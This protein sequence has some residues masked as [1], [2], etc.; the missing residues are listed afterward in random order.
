V[1]DDAGCKVP[2]CCP[3][4]VAEPDGHDSSAASQ[5]RAGRVLHLIAAETVKPG[6]EVKLRLLDALDW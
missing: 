4:S 2:G 1:A 6:V 5:E 3:S